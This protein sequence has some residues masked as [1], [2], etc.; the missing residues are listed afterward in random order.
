LKKTHKST[1]KQTKEHVN[2]PPSLFWRRLAA[3]SL[4]TKLKKLSTHSKKLKS[5]D[6]FTPLLEQQPEGPDWS[7]IEDWT[8]LKGITTVLEFPLT[9]TISVP[10]QTPNWSIVADLTSTL[11]RIRR[12]PLQCREHLMNIVIPREDHTL[13]ADEPE[14]KK[15]KSRDGSVKKTKSRRDQRTKNLVLHDNGKNQ[16]KQFS[17]CFEWVLQASSKRKQASK[18]A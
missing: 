15:Y 2:V 3:D 18:F 5:K 9:L 12:S 4:S 17:Q 7:H 11:S 6:Q 13:K 10:A 8:L 1:V 16:T 14:H